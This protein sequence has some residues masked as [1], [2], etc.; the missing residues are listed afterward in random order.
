MEKNFYEN[1]SLA[2]AQEVEKR[3]KDGFIEINEPEAKAG[4]L[5][6]LIPI[7]IAD[8]KE[9]E[10]I[11]NTSKVVSGVVFRDVTDKL[12]YVDRVVFFPNTEYPIVMEDAHEYAPNQK[13]NEP[14]IKT[15]A[16]VFETKI[17]S[18][19]LVQEELDKLKTSPAYDYYIKKVA[20]PTERGEE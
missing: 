13:I 16:E 9:L 12:V 8:E 19:E 5:A 18:G 20:K 11:F 10:N 1:A 17:D 7:K 14:I 15:N 3:K 2:I 6:R 4:I